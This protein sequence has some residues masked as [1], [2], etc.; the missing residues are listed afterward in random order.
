[1]TKSHRKS[2][3]VPDG[4]TDVLVR[5]LTTAIVAFVVLNLKEWV[6]T[7]EWDLLA[8]AIDAA[9]VA[10]GIFIFY[11]ILMTA[12]R[13]ARRTNNDALTVPARQ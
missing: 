1:M 5:T 10:G 9:C 11:T 8:C 6:E 3:A 4:W 13:G 2:L 7:A 12:S